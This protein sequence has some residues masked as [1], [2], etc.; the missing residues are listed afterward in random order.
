MLRNNVVRIVFYHCLF[1]YLLPGRA[2]PARAQSLPGIVRNAAGRPLP[3]VMLHLTRLTD[4]TRSVTDWSDRS[5]RFSVVLPDTGRYEL[6]ARLLGYEPLRQ[7]IRYL[8]TDTV[9]F[10]TLSMT[11]LARTLTTVTVTAKRDPFEISADKVV[12][13]VAGNT[14]FGGGSAIDVLTNTPRVQID[15]ISKSIRVDGKNGI[16]VY[17]N[18]RQIYL[19]ADQVSKYLES[20]PANSIERIEV[21]TN[22]SARYD[23]S[24][25]GVISVFT[26]RS[27]AEGTTGELS[28]SPGYGRFGKF[29]GVLSGSVRKAT[30]SAYALLTPQVK[31]TYFSYNVNQT[32]NQ[33]PVVGSIAGSQYRLIDTRQTGLRLGGD[34]ALGKQTTVGTNLYFFSQAETTTPT[35]QTDYTLTNQ[36][37]PASS[38][39]AR[40]VLDNTLAN[41]LA[42]VNARR[43][44]SAMDASISADVDYASYRDNSTS[45]A[46]YQDRAEPVP[47]ALQSYFPLQVALKS[48][49]LDG[50]AKP[51]KDITIEGGL[52]VSHALIQTTPVVYTFTPVFAPLIPN[53]VNPFTYDE[54]VQAGYLTASGTLKQLSWQ[55][56]MRLEHT[57]TQETARSLTVNRNY[58]NPFPSLSVQYKL[59]T[60]AQLSLAYNRRIIR[61][62][63]SSLNPAYLFFDPFTIVLGNPLLLPQLTTNVQL[64]YQLASKHAWTL[65]YVSTTNRITEVVYRADTLSPVL[66]NTQINFDRE[67]RVTASYSFPLQPV[68]NWRIQT[69]VTGQQVRYSTAAEGQQ[70]VVSQRTAV[71]NNTHSVKLGGG[72]TLDAQLIYRTTAAIGFMR[73]KPLFYM[74]LGV[75]R[76]LWQGRGSLKVSGTDIFH[77]TTIANYGQYLNTDVSFRHRYESQQVFVNVA[78]RLGNDKLKTVNRRNTAL[79]AEQDRL[80]KE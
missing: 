45:L 14:L 15:P 17:V 1:L 74:N 25:G 10:C 13:N 4:T 37:A 73:Y 16:Q 2:S 23:A 41:V 3:G 53:L 21:L 70:T 19:T 62:S 22:P 65:G 20:L 50:L 29:S 40:T 42:N 68:A 64:S 55:A 75:G 79:D 59:P 43:K 34:A 80:K 66:Y 44:F 78:Y 58:I 76:S 11:E 6:V 51:M 26:K 9:R 33:P 61:P 7:L 30:W 69:T 71:I 35:S 48:V 36:I 8:P 56:G 12:V 5:G 32:I 46:T 31:R 27:T 54:T 38:I 52:K 49:K 77:T 18:N 24:G 72:W 28:L 60:K 63:F 39:S 57:R 47:N 67:T